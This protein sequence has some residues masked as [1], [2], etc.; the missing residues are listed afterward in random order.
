VPNL[1]D[2]PQDLV[3]LGKFLKKLKYCINFELLPYHKLGIS[4]Y[5]QLGFKYKL[6][7]TSAPTTRQL[8]KAK[9]Y[10]IKGMK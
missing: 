7:K 4:K 2:A 9:S 10:I 6:T 5:T 1:T 8:A 3:Q